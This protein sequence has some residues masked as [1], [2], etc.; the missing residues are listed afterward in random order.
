MSSKPDDTRAKGVPPLPDRVVDTSPFTEA[1]V[2]VVLGGAVCVL[3]VALFNLSIVA[4]PFWS[5]IATSRAGQYGALGQVAQQLPRNMASPPWVRDGAVLLGAST[6]GLGIPHELSEQLVG[7]R[8]WTLWEGWVN[9][10]ELLG[11]APLAVRAGAREVIIALQVTYVAEGPDIPVVQKIRRT[12]IGPFNPA[13]EY[14]RELGDLA[15]GSRQDALPASRLA[16]PLRDLAGAYL[17]G[18]FIE[19]AQPRPLFWKE[20]ELIF[21]H[22]NTQATLAKWRAQPTIDHYQAYQDAV[23]WNR[24]LTDSWAETRRVEGDPTLQCLNVR[25]L[26]DLT[27][28]LRAHDV[29][30]SW[31]LFPENPMY[32]HLRSEGGKIIAPAEMVPAARALL[33]RLAAEQEVA[34]LDLFDLC[35]PDEFLDLYH[36]TPPARAKL[37][38]AIAPLLEGGTAP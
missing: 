37:G 6:A 30:V 21:A 2:R 16:G 9:P 36:V 18:R 34:Y 22:P 17:Q 25:A 28:Y 38:A 19:H 8:V 10:P 3:L 23:G 13:W 14:R 20:A 4:R 24:G 15:W 32:R 7:R 33:H 26:R 29:R 31:A 11:L 12:Y 5:M 27:A 1:P 35:G